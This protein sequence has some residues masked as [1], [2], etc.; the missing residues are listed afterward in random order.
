MDSARIII[1]DSKENSRKFLRECLNRN[2]FQIQAETRNAPDLLRRA[3]TMYPDLVI[4]DTNIEG[5]GVSEIA[6]ILQDDEIADVL[7]IGESENHQLR[8]H[9]HILKPYSPETLI[10]AVEICL[11]Y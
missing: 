10:T 5:G 8:E 1:A 9:A 6:G 2:G 11:F 4:L 3:R 7:I